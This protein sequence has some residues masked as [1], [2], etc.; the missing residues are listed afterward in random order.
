[1][2]VDAVADGDGTPGAD[3]GQHWRGRQLGRARVR[4]D[5]IL[6]RELILLVLLAAMPLAEDL[7]PGPRPRPA[8]DETR[9]VIGHYGEGHESLLLFERNTLVYAMAGRQRIALQR[10]AP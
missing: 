9:A 5:R 7:A 2:Y 4:G 10:T 3:R 6:M 8:T 1:R